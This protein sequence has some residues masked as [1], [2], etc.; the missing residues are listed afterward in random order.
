MPRVLLNFS[1]I[2]VK[3]NLTGKTPAIS[4]QLGF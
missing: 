3:L 2:E 4:V 1:Y